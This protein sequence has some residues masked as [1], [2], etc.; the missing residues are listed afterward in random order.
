MKS[1]YYICIGNRNGLRV[2]IADQLNRIWMKAVVQ[3]VVELVKPP[4]K[5]NKRSKCIHETSPVLL[6]SLVH[7]RST[8]I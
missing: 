6:Q 7:R 3:S 5:C 1:D 2:I 8:A 4:M